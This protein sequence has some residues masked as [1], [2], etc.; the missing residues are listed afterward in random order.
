V[1]FRISLTRLLQNLQL[2]RLFQDVLAV[3]IWMDF[4]KGLQSYGGFKLRESVPPNFQ[5]S[6]VVVMKLYIESPNVLKSFECAQGPLSPCQVWLG[7][8]FTHHQ[9]AQ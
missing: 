1:N 6:L 8:D 7:S 4:L 9:G 3:K 2:F 5:H